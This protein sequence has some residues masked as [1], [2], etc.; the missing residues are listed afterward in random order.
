MR[1]LFTTTVSAG[2]LALALAACG[3]APTQPHLSSP[4]AARAGS[5]GG[6]GDAGVET[7][8]TVTYLYCE[9]TGGGGIYYNNTY[10]EAAASGGSGSYTWSWD[11]IV[12]SGDENSSIITGVC[13]DSYPVTVTVTDGT[14][15]SASRSGTF[16]CYARSYGGGGGLEP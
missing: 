14:G 8:L 4:A 13:T 11:V 1:H 6:I 10:C 2:I 16:R 5:G 9:D 15:A 3:D 7:A 12:T